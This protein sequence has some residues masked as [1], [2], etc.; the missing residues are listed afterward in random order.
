ATACRRDIER[1]SSDLESLV[2]AA[3][4]QGR[5]AA[6]GP[7]IQA[8]S[9]ELP[10]Y[11]AAEKPVAEPLKAVVD[12]ASKTTGWQE[13]IAIAKDQQGPRAALIEAAV[14]D[15]ARRELE[16]ALRQIDK[17]NAAVL[18]AKFKEL[19]DGVSDWWNLLRPNET[20]FFAAVGQRAGT[21]RTIDFKAGLSTK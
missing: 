5:L 10:H 15:Q 9:D 7:A 1:Y 21:L 13:L 3:H 18:D 12:T 17:G 4:I 6:L 8:L 2:S 16:Q 14:Y 19:S 11:L 20:S